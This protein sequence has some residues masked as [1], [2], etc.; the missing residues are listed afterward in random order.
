MK[1][2]SLPLFLLLCLNILQAQQ[3]EGIEYLRM[4]PRANVISYDNENHIEHLRYDVS[5]YLFPISQ[6]WTTNTS[7]GHIELSQLFFVPKDWKGYRIFYRM[8]APAGY[9][10]FIG[11]QLIG[12]SHDGAAI[13]EFDVSEQMRYGKDN[14]LSVRYIG[15]DGTLLEAFGLNEPLQP[16]HC[17][18]LLKPQLNVQDYT[19]VADYSPATQVGE[20]TVDVD[21]F[22]IKKKGRCYLEVELWDPQG[23]KV[24]KVGKWCFFDKRTETSQTITSSVAKAM[25]WNAEVP[26]LYTAVIRLYDEKMDIQ[27]LVGTRF[28]FRTIDSRSSLSI[29]G[30]KLTIKG[31]VISPELANDEKQLRNM[32]MQMKCNNIN[33]IR[34]A[35]TLPPAE[36]F[37]EL[38]DELG[39][40]VVCDAYLAPTSNMG[41]AV[42]ADNSYSDFFADKVRTMYGQFKNH[43][44]IIAWS[45]G[46]SPDNGSCMQTAYHALRQLDS[47]RP[48]LYTGALYSDNTDIIAPIRCNSDLLG[49]YISKNHDRSLVMLSYGGVAGNS[50]GGMTT[51]WQKVLDH[52]KIQGGFF[53]CGRWSSIESRPYLPELKQLYRPFD[54][55]M[56]SVSTDAAEF[57]ITNLCDFRTLSDYRL[58]YVIYTNLKPDVVSGDVP[59][60]LKPNEGKDFKLKIPQLTLYAGEEL[61]IKFVLRQRSNTPT[62]PK[63]TELYFAQFPLPST[64][65]E[66]YA[67]TD[68]QGSAFVIET[69]SAGITH[70]SNNNI[71]LN[72]DTHQGVITDVEYRGQKVITQSPNLTFSRAYSPNDHDDPNGL[73]Q[74]LR[75]NQN[76]A[77]VVAT[78]CRRVDAT[79]VGIDVM[80]QYN[81]SY[82]VLFDVRQAYLILS[83]GDILINND[84]TVSEQIKSLARVGMQLDV[85]SHFDT[86]EWFGRSIESYSDR[87]AAGMIWQQKKPVREVIE[88]YDGQPQH[89][90]NRVDTRWAAINNGRAGLYVDIIDTLCN[91]S[92]DEFHDETKMFA[93][94]DG[95]ARLS[96]GS[97][98]ILHI[99][100]AMAG[101]G[102]A[103]S[104]INLSERD[105]L[106]S[107]KYNFTVHL[108][109][110]DCEENNAQDF[111]RIVY[112]KVVSNITE[113]PVIRKSRDRFDGP[114]QVSITC[115]T[116]H[117]QI[118]YTLDGTVPTEKSLL[119]TKPFTIQNT[120]MV[121]ARAFKQGEAPS[122]VATE[123]FSFD[124]VVSCQFAHKPNTPYNKNASKA[125]FDGEL[126][127]ANDLSRGWL[128]FSGHDVQIDME[129]GKPITMDAVTLRFAH[130][131]DAW[132]FAPEQVMVAVSSDGKEYTDFVPAT[133]SYD[134]ASESMNTTQLQII[135]IPMAHENVRFVRI[136][137]KP[138]GRIPQWHRAKGLKPWIMID[139][140]AIK[141]IIIK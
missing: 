15:S 106:K 12:V 119:Y 87:K 48:I 61:F 49:Q 95:N 104:G 130:V 8:Q 136:V 83:S 74:W 56:T 68:Y 79:S 33:A 60:A 44:S 54:I 140:V 7:E 18:F 77:E 24:D 36:R 84:I 80:T 86:L 1:K 114:M 113:L 17:E 26:R 111:R 62:I 13:T 78:N 52:E 82:G 89:E 99:D 21:M 28:G 133:I 23:H 110:Y 75:Y 41:Q 39:F 64:S 123:Q 93:A 70:V 103:M 69:D 9:G 131:P 66:C 134:A 42:A 6:D 118:R 102:G 109:P 11:D 116:P 32:M 100:Y 63:N 129:L 126:G 59:M 16:Q 125:L 50:F 29:N 3:P 51:L 43:P 94:M 96:T 35:G 90:G 37:L 137:A 105:L 14:R 53:D 47:S 101:V 25:P 112:P 55:K 40:Y 138:I 141:E 107:H 124:Y 46:N 139:E 97:D 120:V 115:P 98:W 22:N 132:V 5:P 135:T 45:L 19:I 4:A 92:I 127:D 128:G 91:F 71:S 73:K 38:C 58:E 121:K 67:Y 122:F 65:V 31:V 88:H 117:A 85:P 34:Y 76:Q 10:F 30:Q 57:L 81:S 27:D 2:L 108:R 20:Y 72:F